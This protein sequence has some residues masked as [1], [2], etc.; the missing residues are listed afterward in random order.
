MCFKIKPWKS[1]VLPVWR[2]NCLC[3]IWC[4]SRHPSPARASR[5]PPSCSWPP[6]RAGSDLRTNLEHQRLVPEI[7]RSREHRERRLDPFR[8]QCG[9]GLGRSS[10]SACWHRHG[11]L[12]SRLRPELFPVTRWIR[13]N[14]SE[15]KLSQI[16]ILVWLFVLQKIGNAYKYHGSCLWGWDWS[17]N[18]KTNKF[19]TKFRPKN[20]LPSILHTSWLDLLEYIFNRFFLM[21]WILINVLDCPVYKW[22]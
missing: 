6:G 17:L 2:W 18:I 4:S 11:S 1:V 5:T 20:H 22:G 19:Q 13:P 12:D 21:N 16:N 9:S 3:H 7:R 14:E 10:G 8:R 15:P